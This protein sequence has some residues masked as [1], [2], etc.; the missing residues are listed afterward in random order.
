MKRRTTLAALAL[1][2]CLALLPAAAR[3]ADASTTISGTWGTLQWT[4]H[5]DTG[6]LDITG[7]GPMPDT[8]L[9]DEARNNA[10]SLSIGSGITTI[11]AGAFQNM[12]LASVTIPGTVTAIGE[13]AF[14]GNDS[15]KSVVIPGTVSTIGDSAFADNSTLERVAIQEES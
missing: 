14:A 11:S 6:A 12:D 2:L 15:L 9:P 4:C 8:P 13:R 1:G 5:T 7:S 10:R 3:A